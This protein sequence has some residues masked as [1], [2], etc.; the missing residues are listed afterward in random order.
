MCKVSIITVCKNEVK[1]IRRT[2]E[3]VSSQIFRDFELIVIDGGSTDGTQ[4]V[5]NEY[6]GEITYFVSESDAGIFAGQNKGI[7]VAKG[8][9][10]LF[11][12]GGDAVHDNSVL[13][14]IFLTEPTDDILYGNLLIEE[15]DGS[16]TLG[17]SPP[18]ITLDFLLRGTLWHPV[19]FIKRQLFEKFGSFNENLKIVAD[20]EFFVKVILIEEVS[21]RHFPRTISRFNTNG[22]GTDPGWKDVHEKERRQ[23]QRKYFSKSVLQ[24]FD[25]FEK[26]RILNEVL[27]QK[28]DSLEYGKQSGQR[29]PLLQVIQK[30]PGLGNFFR[31][32]TKRTNDSY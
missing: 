16:E 6:K 31:K 10:L 26:F 28:I 19:S 14:E 30:L 11:I 1:G 3:S 9:Y 22:V 24:M 18:E 5:I 15:Q 13:E 7:K 27:K 20:Y 25:D 21:T 4:D 2:L 23:V 29:R 12:N 17:L 8:D 32:T